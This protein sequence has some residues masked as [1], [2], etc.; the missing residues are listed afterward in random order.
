MVKQDMTTDEFAKSMSGG[1]IDELKSFVSSNFI[2]F[3]CVS[4]SRVCNRAAHE[5]AALGVGSVKGRS[6]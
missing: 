2:N 5:L 6:T 3:K 1:L 4:R